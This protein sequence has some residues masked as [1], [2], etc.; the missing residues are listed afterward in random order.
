MLAGADIIYRNTCVTLYFK[1]WILLIKKI[2]YIDNLRILRE[3][4]W[5]PTSY[6]NEEDKEIYV[7]PKIDL[8]GNRFLW[9]SFVTDDNFGEVFFNLKFLWESHCNSNQFEI[10]RIAPGSLGLRVRKQ[11]K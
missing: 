3:C 10:Y 6:F 7:P 5:E 11:D 9:P 1:T 2:I 8:M 4:P